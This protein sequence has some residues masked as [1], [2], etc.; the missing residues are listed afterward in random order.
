MNETTLFL[1]QVMGP[2][3]AI[4]GLGIILNSHNLAK[5]FKDLN[6]EPFALFMA[7]MAMIALGMAIV[8]KHFLWGSLPEVLVSIVGLAILVKGVMLAIMPNA[9][10]KL[11][12]SILSPLL[13]RA[14]GVIW[15]IG[16]TY[17]CY[18]GFVA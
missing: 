1:V 5:A 3:F 17:F 6:K 12:D 7:S 18:I 16:G 13:A 11:I 9:F 15:L 14:G 8:L 2:I 10:N 4:V